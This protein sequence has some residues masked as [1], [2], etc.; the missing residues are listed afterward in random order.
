MM[1]GQVM[2]SQQLFQ[3]HFVVDLPLLLEQTRFVT[4]YFPAAVYFLRCEGIFRCLKFD[5][6]PLESQQKLVTLLPQE[7]QNWHFYFH[8]CYVCWT[9]YGDLW[10]F[11]LECPFLGQSVADFFPEFQS[12]RL[13]SHPA[14]DRHREAPALCLYLI[15]KH[16]K[17]SKITFGWM[18]QQRQAV[19]ECLM[20]HWLL[21][22]MMMRS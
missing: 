16:P 4:D 17:Y 6:V 12:H 13:R 19:V 18:V 11:G 3:M 1:A 5:Y 15:E 9:K 14:Q 7:K 21:T 10:Q 2:I 8:D 22:W 20:M